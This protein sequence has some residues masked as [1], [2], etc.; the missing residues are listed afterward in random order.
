MLRTE[1]EDGSERENACADELSRKRFLSEGRVPSL[2]PPPSGGGT[3]S[4]MAPYFYY[5][6]RVWN[7]RRLMSALCV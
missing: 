6:I 1:D 5:A 3:S 2:P 4:A 7:P